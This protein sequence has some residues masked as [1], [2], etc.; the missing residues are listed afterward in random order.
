MQRTLASLLNHVIHIEATNHISAL[1]RIPV[2]DII[3]QNTDILV[4]I[5]GRK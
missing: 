4:D 1:P 3:Q 5:M 2:E